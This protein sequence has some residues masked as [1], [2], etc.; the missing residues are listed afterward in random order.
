LDPALADPKAPP[1]RD[2]R[3]D[4]LPDGS[5]EGRFDR[6]GDSLSSADLSVNSAAGAYSSIRAESLGDGAARARG[7]VAGSVPV[8]LLVLIALVLGWLVWR[9]LFKAGRVNF[10][11]QDGNR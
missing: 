1:L 8:G 3:M 11:G 9:F 5:L 6:S 4:F 7:P 2:S 10:A